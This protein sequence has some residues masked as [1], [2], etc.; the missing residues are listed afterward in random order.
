MT[1]PA[2][3]GAAGEPQLGGG[4]VWQCG[5]MDVLAITITEDGGGPIM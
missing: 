2:F 3:C 5:T 1:Q 4:R